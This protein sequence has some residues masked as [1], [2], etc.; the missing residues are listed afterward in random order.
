MDVPRDNPVQ[1]PPFLLFG[2]CVLCGEMQS[3]E[4]FIFGSRREEVTDVTPP[5]AEVVSSPSSLDELS[6]LSISAI[7]KFAKAS[8]HSWLTCLSVA[9]V[10]V[11]VAAVEVVYC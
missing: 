8:P 5:L 2:F 11:S 3:G 4:C 7:S 10:E 1:S 6:C 9:A